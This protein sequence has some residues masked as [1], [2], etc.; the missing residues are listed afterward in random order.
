MGVSPGGPGVSVVQKLLEVVLWQAEL[1]DDLCALG[2][3]AVAHGL[4]WGQGG[5]G[6]PLPEL[7]EALYGVSAAGVGVYE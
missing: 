2:G 5:S 6:M 1:C 4:V 3:I 7:P